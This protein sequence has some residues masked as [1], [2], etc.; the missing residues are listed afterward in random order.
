MGLLLRA[1]FVQSESSGLEVA[2]QLNIDSVI[3]PVSAARDG[4]GAAPQ[5]AF[6]RRHLIHGVLVESL[7]P[8]CRERISLAAGMKE[9]ERHH[10]ISVARR[11]LSYG[12]LAVVLGSDEAI[13]GSTLHGVANQ[14][15]L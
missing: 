15:V 10:L 5:F 1:H 9:R 6:D 14:L 11:G 3:H 2:A 4:R 7:Q 8:D 12:V 13:Q